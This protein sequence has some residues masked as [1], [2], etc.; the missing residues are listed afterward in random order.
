MLA[1]N[2][3]ASIFPDGRIHVPLGAPRAARYQIARFSE[4]EG[5]AQDAY[6]YHLTP[7][8]LETARKQ[9]LRIQHLETLIAKDIARLFHLDW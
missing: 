1:E 8:S 7:S 5:F 9:G 3:Q 4:W 6:R 2:E